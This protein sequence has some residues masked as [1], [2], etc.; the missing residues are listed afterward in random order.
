MTEIRGEG[1][2]NDNLETG[3]RDNVGISDLVQLQ[4][5]ATVCIMMLHSVT[6]F[7]LILKLATRISDR[8]QQQIA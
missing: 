7:V 2:V 3:L 8:I 6:D 5:S 4:N 1:E